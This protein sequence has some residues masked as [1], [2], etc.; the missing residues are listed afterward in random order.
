MFTILAVTGLFLLLTLSG[1]DLLVSG[2]SSDEL[3]RMGLQE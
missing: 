2:L 1:A 3:R